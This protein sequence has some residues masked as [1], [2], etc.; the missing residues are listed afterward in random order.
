M[1]FDIVFLWV[2]ALNLSL[3]PFLFMQRLHFL[4]I[5]SLMCGLTGFFNSASNLFIARLVEAL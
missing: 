3:A 4:A 1:L 2:G 5:A